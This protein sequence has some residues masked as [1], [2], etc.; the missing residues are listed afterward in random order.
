[1]FKTNGQT[2]NEG[3]ENVL[4]CV[5]SSCCSFY[6]VKKN[7]K[8]NKEVK[9][10]NSRKTMYIFNV[11]SSSMWVVRPNF[12]NLSIRNFLNIHFRICI[13]QYNLKELSSSYNMALKTTLF[14]SELGEILFFLF[15]L[16][17]ACIEVEETESSLKIKQFYSL[18]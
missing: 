15:L 8:K 2:H 16:I 6:V 10:K 14:M 7:K 5:M 1:M 13:L 11:G 12:F 9:A 4:H 17:D 3:N 18:H